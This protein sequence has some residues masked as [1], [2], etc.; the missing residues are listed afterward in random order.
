[1]PKVI[2]QDRIARLVEVATD[3]FIREGYRRTQMED[4]ALALGTGKGTLYG[5]VQSKAALFDLLVRCADSA[6]PLPDVTSL[7]LATPRPGSTVD[8]VRARLMREVENLELLTALARP[9]P[10]D[11]ATE[12]AC[13]LDDLY[14]R[15]SRNR[16]GIKLVDSSARD[17]PELA[18][19]WFGQGRWAQHAAL[20]AYLEQRIAKGCLR[21]VPSVPVAARLM[22]E[23]VAFWAVHG[24][25]DSSPQSVSEDEVRAT[26]VQMTLHGVAMEGR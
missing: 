25:W 12:L 3:V 21:A 26:L 15:M 4:V 13:I 2:S 9:A 14:V 20:A 23:C 1:M 8:F 16:R 6:E 17:Y 22:L 11:A 19:V 18:E 7:P 5:Y 10:Q 24:H